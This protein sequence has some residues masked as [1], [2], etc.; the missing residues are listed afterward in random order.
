MIGGWGIRLIKNQSCLLDNKK[1]E[2]QKKDSLETL[3][4]QTRG[5]SKSAEINEIG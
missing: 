2:I 5:L 1:E 3:G 4:W